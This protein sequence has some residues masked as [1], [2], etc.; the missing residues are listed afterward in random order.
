MPKGAKQKFKLIY[1]IKYLMENTD[2]NHK[3][4]MQDIIKYLESYDITAERKSI[5]ADMETIRDIGIDVVGEKIGRNF[6]YYIA[7]RDFEIA[8]LKL[9]VDAIQSSKFMTEKKSQDLIKKLEGLVSVHGAKQLQRQV[10]V[11]GRTKTLNESV[12]Y[13]I[14]ALHNAIGSNRKIKFQYFRWNLKKEMELR[15]NGEFYEVSPWALLWEDE[16][17]YLIAHDKEE[18]K[19]KT[20]EKTI[21]LTLLLALPCA[22]FLIYFAPFSV[23]FLFSRLQSQEKIV[24]VNLLRLTAPCVILIPFVHTSN[25][26]LVGRG[27]LYAPL[28]SSGVGVA[29]KIITMVI[30]LKIPSF[31][32]YGVGIGLIACYFV[33]GLVNLIIITLGKVSYAGKTYRNRQYAS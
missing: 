19:I 14:D 24:A 22:L 3:A 23:N 31:N 2:E 27:K 28:I 6:Y 18:D 15:R 10:Y 32:I 17:Y 33:T 12:F 5:Y 30:L 29:V 20:T 9:L 4:T 21:I 11:S 7:S 8:E 16:N 13:N 25:G 26:A 1:I